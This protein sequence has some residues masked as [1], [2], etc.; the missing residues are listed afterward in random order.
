MVFLRSF[1]CWFSC[2]SFLSNSAFLAKIFLPL[3]SR[4][5]SFERS[6]LRFCTRLYLTNPNLWPCLSFLLTRNK[7]TNVPNGLRISLRPFTST[8]VGRLD[9]KMDG[10]SR[11]DQIS[12]LLL[13]C[14]TFLSRVCQLKFRFREWWSFHRLRPCPPW[15]RFIPPHNNET[16]VRVKAALL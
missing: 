4:L 14:G 3:H 8:N 2:L 13:I 12:S 16:H 9:M 5:F 6:T 1:F 15:E 10:A 7:S 11:K